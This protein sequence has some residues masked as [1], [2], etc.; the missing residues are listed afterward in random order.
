MPDGIVVIF[1]VVE[2]PIIRE[3]KYV[4][5]KKV[6]PKT[7]AKE[8]EIKVG[9]A[10]D[11]HMIEDARRRLERYYH[12][13]G[14]AKASISTAEGTQPDD[15]RVVF[16]INEGNKQRVWWTQFEGNTIANDSRLRTQ[17]QSK[18]GILWFIGGYVDPKKIEEDKERLTAYYRSLGYFQAVVSR[19]LEY[20]ED[21]D[22]LTITYV[23]NEG[24][25]YKVRNVSVIGNEKFAAP[26]IQEKFA[27]KAGEFFDQAKLYKDVN[28][29]RDL[30]GGHGYISADIEA[31]TRFVED[32]THP[33]EVDLVY[34]I[35]EGN[36]Y[37]IGRVSVRINGD[38]PHTRHRVVRSR[39]SQRPGDIVDTRLI[40]YD[41]ARIKRSSVFENNP[42][43]GQVPKI[44]IIMPEGE[45]QLARQPRRSADEKTQP[46]SGSNVRGQ[47]PDTWPP[48]QSVYRAR[49]QAMAVRSSERLVRTLG[50]HRRI[51]RP[52]G[53]LRLSIKL[54]ALPVTLTQA[55]TGQLSSARPGAASQQRFSGLR[56]AW[57][58][59]RPAGSTAERRLYRTWSTFRLRGSA[60]RQ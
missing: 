26:E 35:A 58:A 41:E 10:M 15:R 54:P 7:L 17:I 50:R 60:S 47:S 36:Q 59:Q 40:R 48:R 51:A 46:R 42:A 19:D 4:G 11:P 21:R 45:E 55:Q 9:D 20:D 5:Y 2:R 43:K 38:N 49:T 6:K 18:P 53:H 23:M 27:L 3:I 12:E 31:D 56:R 24:I 57:A 8:S 1:Q 14:F 44:S 37:R 39:L 33:G 25:R 34:D 22:W 13:H 16:L 30:Y 29:I 32:P 28:S 52:L